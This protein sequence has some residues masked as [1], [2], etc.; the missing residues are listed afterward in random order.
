MQARTMVM[1]ATSYDVLVK[2]VV[3]YP[4]GVTIDFGKKSHTTAQGGK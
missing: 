2:G 4:L 1:H 3:L